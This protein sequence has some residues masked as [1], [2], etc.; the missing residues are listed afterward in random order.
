MHELAHD[1]GDF[2]SKIIT[3]PN[4]IVVCGLKSLKQE[5]EQLILSSPADTV[6][7]VL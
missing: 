1:L 6:L 4:L 5:L 7:N 3:Y 2:V